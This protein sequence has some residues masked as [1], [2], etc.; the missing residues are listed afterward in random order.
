VGV[1]TLKRSLPR[2]AHP[3]GGRSL[4]VF[5]GVA[6]EAE[7]SLAGSPLGHLV[8]FAR[9]TF[10][11]TA[12]LSATADAELA[13]TIR[14]LGAEAGNS[15]GWEAYGG[16]V[17]DVY[18]DHVPDVYAA[19]LFSHASGAGETAELAVET[20]LCNTTDQPAATT[21]H[22]VVRDM[23]GHALS[24]TVRDLVLAPGRTALTTAIPI[25][26]PRLWA[27]ETPYLYGLSAELRSAHGIHSARRRAGIRT[28][29]VRGRRFYLNGRRLFLKGVCRHDTWLDQ[30]YTLTREQMRHDMRDIKALGANFV[31]LVHYPHHPEILDLAD[32]LGLFV[33]EEPGLWNVHLGAESMARPKEVALE[34]MRRTILRDRGHPC[35]F[36]WLLGNECWPDGAYLNEG[37]RLCNALD[38]GRLVGFSHLHDLDSD[39]RAHHT[40]PDWNPDFND[41]HPYSEVES[42]YRSAMRDFRDKPLI[43]GEWGGY[44]VWRDAWLMEQLGRAFATAA[45]APPTPPSNW[46]ASPTGS[47]PIPA[48]TTGGSLPAPREC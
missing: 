45:H 15:P 32:E 23:E 14:D 34:I 22:L 42:L 35:V 30:G 8:A 7:V 39:G 2:T 3:S 4:L 13:V 37:Q 16:I 33:T 43:L 21:L 36:A 31:R 27:P 10:D 5:E 40:F 19:D 26:Q 1:A 20:E 18:L 44:W 48:N 41:T 46:R 29:E 25:A 24:E 11:V 9:H 38:P 12:L 6:N 17:R 28:V 47:G